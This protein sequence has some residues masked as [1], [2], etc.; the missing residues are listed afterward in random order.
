[1][2][3]D[4]DPGAVR[5]RLLI[6]GATE[7]EC[8]FL[9]SGQRVELNAMTSDEFVAFVERKLEESGVKKVVPESEMLEATYGAMTRSARAKAA[10]QSELDH[11]K[12][13]AVAAP[14]DLMEKV[15]IHLTMHPVKTWDEAVWAIVEEDA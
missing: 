4:K 10:L 7:A 8:R 14:K 15:K 9:L 3:I 6:N 2:A 5:R 11:L 1:V 12:D 13:E